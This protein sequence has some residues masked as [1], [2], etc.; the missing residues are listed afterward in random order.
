[1]AQTY[2]KRQRVPY[3]PSSEKPYRISRSKIDQFMNCPFC[4]WLDHRK[5]V[6]QPSGPAFTLNSAVD[7]LLKKEFDIHRAKNSTHPL[8]KEYGVDAIPFSHPQIETWRANFTGINFVHRQTNFEVFGAIDDI[9]ETPEKKLHIVD[10]KATSKAGDIVLEDTKWHN[11]YRRQMEI[12]QWLFRRNNFDISDTGYFVYVN[13]RKD[14][15]AFDGKLEFTLKIIPYEGKDHW[16]EGILFEMK[17]VLGSDTP[18]TP[19]DDCPFCIYR[20]SISALN[21]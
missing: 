19:K 10:Y 11:Q 15:A 17:E 21:L 14:L 3:D 18:P 6:T 7:T 4:S 5:G 2:Y 12:Y 8:M 1:M 16:V 20:A 13:G 9:W